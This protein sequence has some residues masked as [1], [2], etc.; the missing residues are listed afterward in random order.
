MIWAIVIFFWIFSGIH[1][2]N[3]I[4]FLQICPHC[5]PCNYYISRIET[6]RNAKLGGLGI[7]DR[8]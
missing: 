4:K 1:L 2:P 6:S 3:M 5:L 8:F 7:L